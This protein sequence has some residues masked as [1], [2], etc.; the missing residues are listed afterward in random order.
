MELLTSEKCSHLIKWMKFPFMVEIVNS[1]G[2]KTTLNSMGCKLRM[3]D[4]G[5][6]EIDP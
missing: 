5:S 3:L 6:F 4:I 1:T 2:T